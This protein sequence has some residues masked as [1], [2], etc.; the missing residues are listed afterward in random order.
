MEFN[1]IYYEPE[2]AGYEL[3]KK[4]QA[5]FAGSRWIP[6]ENHNSIEELRKKPNSEFAAMKRLLIVGTRK[7]HVYRKNEKVSDFLVPFTSS[8]CTA[9]CLY[10]YLVCHYNKCSYL[11]LFVNREEM[12]GKLLKTA[13]KDPS[14]TFEIGSNSDLILE[15]TITGNLE[16]AIPEFTRH[17]HGFLTFPTKFSMVE[18]LLPLN[19]RGRVIVR[20]SVNPQ[21][22]ISQ[23]ELGTSGLAHRIKALN[24][25]C[26]AGYRIGILIAPVIFVEGWER[27][28]RRLI[29][30][31]AEELSFKARESVFFEIIFMTYSYVHRAI[32]SEAFPQASDLYD[33]ALMMGRGP[34]RYTYKQSARAQGEAFL[35]EELKLHFP[36][37]QILYVV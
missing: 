37:S 27:L 28:Y 5:Q 18:P 34:G 21:E 2:I 31:L 20:M 22:I 9:A 19:H 36:G 13:A 32:N 17:E 26:E 4:L 30:R 6:I 12:L 16:W 24:Q 25:L 3:G 23:I 11:R 29:E 35:R 1:T 15:N 14:L 7:T 10:C 33:K 8:G